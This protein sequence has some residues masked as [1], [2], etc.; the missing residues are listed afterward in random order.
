MNE[1]MNEEFKETSKYK[2]ISLNDIR[3]RYSTF[4]KNYH[5]YKKLFAKV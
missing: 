3:L 5:V 4:I 2:S 1:Q